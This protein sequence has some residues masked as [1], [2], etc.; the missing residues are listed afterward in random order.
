MTRS[1]I[2]R[3]NIGEYVQWDEVNHRYDLTAKCLNEQSDE[4]VRA[5]M[6]FVLRSWFIPQLT[7]EIQGWFTVPV[8][9][10][11]ESRQLLLF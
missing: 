11:K 5:V 1:I 3:H 10:A 7:P 9:E 8:H 4:D 2:G 6:M